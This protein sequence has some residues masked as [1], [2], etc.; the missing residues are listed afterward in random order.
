MMQRG[1]RGRPGGHSWRA[2][3][4]KVRL[5]AG[6]RNMRHNGVQPGGARICFPLVSFVSFKM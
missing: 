5:I 2:E 3:Q 6:A 1:G 4:Q